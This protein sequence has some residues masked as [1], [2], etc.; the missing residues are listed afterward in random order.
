MKP[1]RTYTIL[2]EPEEGGGFYVTIPALPGCFTRGN[3][4]EE[5]R[6]R[7]IE[8]IEVHIAGLLADGEPVPAETDP[9]QLV[10]VTVA[11]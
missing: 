10:A 1:M 9:P 2:V 11:A 7:A 3:T 6:D 8:A 5:C 4:I